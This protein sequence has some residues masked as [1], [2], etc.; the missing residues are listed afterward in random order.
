[1]KRHPD[2]VVGYAHFARAMAMVGHL[3][4]ARQAMARALELNPNL[5]IGTSSG[6]SIMRR[7]DDSTR[8]REANR[9][10]GMPE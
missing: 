8:L 10:A 5:R 3:E 7:P 2:L 4:E 9:L 1:M 6:P